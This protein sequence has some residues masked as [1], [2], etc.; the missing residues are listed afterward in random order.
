MTGRASTSILEVSCMHSRKFR[1]RTVGNFVS[2]QSETSGLCGLKIRKK[3]T[4]FFRN[5]LQFCRIA[6][7]Y[8]VNDRVADSLW[9][10]SGNKSKSGFEDGFDGVK[11]NGSLI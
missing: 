2:V 11:K 1:K 8:Y 7:I 10:T 6:G 3:D 9:K 4:F 5:D